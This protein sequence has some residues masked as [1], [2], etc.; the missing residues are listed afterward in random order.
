MTEFDPKAKWRLG[1]LHAPALATYDHPS[2]GWTIRCFRRAKPRVMRPGLLSYV[3]SP[4]SFLQQDWR[5][6]FSHAA[7]AVTGSAE[8]RD[9]ASRVPQTII[10]CYRRQVGIHKELTVAIS[11]NKRDNIIGDPSSELRESN[12]D[13]QRLRCTNSLSRSNRFDTS[14]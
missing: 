7:S 12:D 5:E 2:E 8:V 14:C 4:R 13:L 11:R 9:P 3:C 6:L 10:G 1:S